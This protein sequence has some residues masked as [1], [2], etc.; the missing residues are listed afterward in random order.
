MRNFIPYIFVLGLAGCMST[1]QAEK[2]TVLDLAEAELT[3]ADGSPAGTATLTRL[4]H[5]VVLD[6]SADAP[7]NGAFG[8]HIHAVGKCEGPDF[9]SSGP[10]W[11]PANKQHGRDNPMGSHAGDMPNVE[12][13]AER[14]L[15]LSQK[16]EGVVF[17]GTGGVIDV[18]GASIIIHE[19]ADDYKTDPSGASGKR[20]ICGVFKVQ[21]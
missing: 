13:N 10:H 1:S 12:A 15:V 21:R 14:K 19:K 17:E 7:G 4:S 8:M 5:G 16:L 9:A 6:L 20:V 18:D 3:R 2:D 11:N